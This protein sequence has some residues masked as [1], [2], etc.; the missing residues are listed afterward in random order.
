M[1]PAPL[2]RA[3]GLILRD[4]VDDPARGI[5]R[6]EVGRRNEGRPGYLSQSQLSRIILGKKGIDLDQLN[7]LCDLF[8]VSIVDIIEQAEIRAAE[9]EQAESRS[10]TVTP[11]RPSVT[12]VEQDADLAEVAHT[13]VYDAEEDTD[14]KYE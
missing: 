13:P 4:L 12:G 10:A 1:P 2:T 11:I 8:E 9:I 14:D 6:M 3:V 7:A 5:T